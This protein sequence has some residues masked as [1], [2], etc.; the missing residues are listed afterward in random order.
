[1][2]SILSGRP[3]GSVLAAP[4]PARDPDYDFSGLPQ[5]LYDSLTGPQKAVYDAP[6]RF[7][8]LCSGRRFG[9]TY[10]CITRLINWAMLNGMQAEKPGQATD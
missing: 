2:P 1:M 5:Q 6:E 8:L 3:R 9:K 7:K 10:L 4:L